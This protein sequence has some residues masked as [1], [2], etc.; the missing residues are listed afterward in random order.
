ME[1][2]GNGM[3]VVMMV[4]SSVDGTKRC[5]AALALALRCLLRCLVDGE[6]RVLKLKG[7]F[8]QD[9]SPSPRRRGVN[10]I[11]WRRAGAHAALLS[12]LTQLT[13]RR[14]GEVETSSNAALS[15]SRRRRRLCEPL[16]DD[17]GFPLARLAGRVRYHYQ[18]RRR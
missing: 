3:E 15:K 18:Q 7:I 2:E 12:Q 17:P 9:S 14:H 6:R 8:A 1:R 16:V 4:A 10:R 11:P 13:R 5:A